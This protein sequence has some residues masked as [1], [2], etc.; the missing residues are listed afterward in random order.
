MLTLKLVKSKTED[1]A[2]AAENLTAP[3]GDENHAKPVLK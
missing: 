2:A 1:E 3:V